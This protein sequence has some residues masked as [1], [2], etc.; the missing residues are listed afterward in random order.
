[1]RSTPRKLN[2]FN[3]VA[4]GQTASVKL[5]TGPTYDKIVLDTNVTEATDI[6]RVIVNLNG[7]E[8]YVLSG[9]ELQVLEKYKKMPVVAGL[10]VIPFADDSCRAWDA[11]VLTSL[12]TL[13][14]DNLTLHVELVGKPDGTAA[15]KM[16]GYSFTSAAR[17]E[18]IWL[19][20]IKTV[21]MQASATGDNEHNTLQKGPAIRR[22][23]MKK[24]DINYVHI[25]RDNLKVYDQSDLVNQYILNRAERAPQAGYFHVD[26]IHT[27]FGIYDRFVTRSANTLVLRANVDSVGPIPLLMETVEQVKLPS[28][29]KAALV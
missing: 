1:M 29:P 26:P 15:P 7:D 18:R 13:P 3:A 5:D 12:V 28:D 23:H 14:T 17:A 4:W 21:Q 27:G 20:R 16:S 6:K 10:Y 2:S 8:I 9:E 25:E 24:A 22:I 11:Q 19:P